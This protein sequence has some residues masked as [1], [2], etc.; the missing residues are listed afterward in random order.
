METP[1]LKVGTV[2]PSL[3]LGPVWLVDPVIPRE[4][5]AVLTVRDGVVEGVDW[6]RAEEAAG[7]AAAAH[8]GY[9]SVCV[10]PNTS[11]PI[12]EASV[13][14]R[15]HKAAADTGLPVEVFALGTVSVGEQGEQLA[16]MGE[17][18]DAGAIG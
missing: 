12:D 16:E 10:M 5:P 7:A 14:A 11:P 8:G 6:L 2:V 15:V 18:A 17:L 9:T 3:V 4:G 1:G 13:L